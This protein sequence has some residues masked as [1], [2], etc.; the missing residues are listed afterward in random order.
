MSVVRIRG[1][2]YSARSDD[3]IDFFKVFRYG[4]DEMYHALDSGVYR[5]PDLAEYVLRLRG[6][7]YDTE[8]RDA[9]KLFLL[10]F[11]LC[12]SFIFPSS[13]VTSA[14]WMGDIWVGWWLG[15]TTGLDIAPNSV[16]L[17]VDHMGRSTG[18]AYVR[19]TS[20]EMLAR[21]KEK[22]MEKIGH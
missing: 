3:I 1:L 22:H 5:H 9:M 10:K 21:A 17:L 14:G 13:D 8:I 19:F 18:E 6:L 7:P 20:A 2:P 11:Y 15:V 12:V 16:G 4:K